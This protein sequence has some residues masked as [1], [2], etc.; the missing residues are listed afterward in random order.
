MIQK[1]KTDLNRN[2]SNLFGWRTNRKIIV[3]E[4]DDWG[5]I[6]MD[7]KNAFDALL[8]AGIPVDACHYN[9]NDALESNEDLEMLMELLSKFKDK[10]NKAP[11]MTGVN[12]VANPDFDKIAKNNFSKY[13]FE[14]F[15]D[16]CARY[17]KHDRVY[18]LWKEACEKRLIVPV[19]HGR[20]HLNVQRWMRALSEGCQSTKSAFDH[21]VTGI[22]E[23]I[24]GQALKNYQ[25]A[26]DLDYPSDLEYQKEV[27]KTGLDIFED[28]YGYRSEFFI[29]T[30]GPFNNGLESICYEEG[31][32]YLGTAKFQKEPLG[33]GKFKNHFRYIGKK[34]PIGMTYLTRNA[35]FEPC[36]WE[37]SLSKDWVSD[38][39]NE[40][41]IAFRWG[42]PATISSHR[43]NYIGLVKSRKP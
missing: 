36:S 1:L 11:V 42:K 29:P 31:V 21:R 25:A 3:I 41:K 2:L 26:F 4:S 27:I 30:N 35:F 32:R 13:E 39:L 20:E 5:S 28:L 37:H 18:S 9:S 38:C 23:G 34:S 43:V 40:I 15:T 22:L 24:N 10:N 19:F 17:P 12:I 7:S 14:L 16:T 8:K 33:N 6:R